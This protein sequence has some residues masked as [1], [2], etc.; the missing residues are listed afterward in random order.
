M[1]RIS[2]I[3]GVGINDADYTVKILESYCE[4][5]KQKSKLVWICPFYVKWK[6]MIERCH[7]TKV[8]ERYPTYIG[9]SVCEEWLKFSNFK[10][11]METQEWEGKQLD[12]DLLF[13][14]NK[15]YSPET[16][17]L[18]D[19]RVN[20]FLL[21]SNASRGQYMIGVCYNKRDSKFL[22]CCRDGKGRP[23]YLGYF[24]NELEAHKAWLSFKLKLAHQLASEQTDPRIA[25]ALIDRY[26]N[27]VTI[28]MYKEGD[29]EQ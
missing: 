18:T 1:A 4:D 20:A 6:S 29:R 27:Y 22:A 15:V 14:G 16:C 19:S 26:E 9:C 23:K 17:V 5:G 12:K 11:W 8:Q 13:P 24:N 2:L 7:S 25:K 10:A 28:G 21:E 3:C